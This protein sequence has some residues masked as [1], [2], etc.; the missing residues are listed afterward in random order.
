[1]KKFLRY[2]LMLM[3]TLLAVSILIV[4]Q[5][6]V[7]FPA[8]PGP[9]FDEDVSHVVLDTLT[10]RRPDMVLLGDSII[11][12]NLD[13]AALEQELGQTIYP[14]N[15]NASSSTLWYLAVKHNIAAAPYKPAYLVIIFRDSILTNPAYRAHAAHPEVMDTFASPQDE[16][17]VQRAYVDR[18]N[19][20]EKIG[21]SY[22]PLYNNRTA[23]RGQMDF[24]IRYPAARALLDCGKRCMDIALDNVLSGDQWDPDLLNS[25]ISAVEDELYTRRALDFHGQLND[26]FLPDILRLCRESSIRLIFVH[27]KTLRYYKNSYEP[28]L[29]EQYLRDLENYLN[30]NSVSYLDLSP[31]ARI[32]TE[33]FSDTI[34]IFP[35]G[36]ERYTQ[37]LADA[38]KTVLP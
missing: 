24:Y 12:L 26:S 27:A 13:P 6:K 20:L 33:D 4:Q 2:I 23:I 9:R 25:H 21:S 38:L 28:A 1:M 14:L 16:L 8:G 30:E 29:L 17:V 5:G 36:V 32:R 3:F 18:M 35:S 22:F 37:A 15:F 34:H 31:D 7:P 11:E 10:A 19:S